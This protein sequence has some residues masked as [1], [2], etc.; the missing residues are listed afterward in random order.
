MVSPEPEV[1]PTGEDQMSSLSWAEAMLY[2]RESNATLP[3]HLP[4]PGP[5]VS[6]AVWA[7]GS[8]VLPQQLSPRG[9]YTILAGSENPTFLFLIN[10]HVHMDY[11]GDAY[12]PICLTC[13]IACIP[14]FSG[15]TPVTSSNKNSCEICFLDSSF[16]QCLLFRETETHQKGYLFTQGFENFCF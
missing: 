5:L 4:P 16:C 3:L 7:W 8:K 10:Q 15:R 6:K 11:L 9:L 13:K 1:C 14:I 2:W 12:L